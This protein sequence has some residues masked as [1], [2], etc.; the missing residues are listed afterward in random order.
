[1]AFAKAC[2]ILAGQPS[3]RFPRIAP[4]SLSTISSRKKSARELRQRRSDYR[5]CIP[6]LAGFVSPQSIA[7]DGRKT[8]VE[9]DEHPRLN[10]EASKTALL[11]LTGGRGFVCIGAMKSVLG[12]ALLFC[13]TG[14]MTLENRHDLYSPDVELWTH[15][16]RT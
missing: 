3:L 16:Q 6:A 15:P 7:P 10:L 14:C 5:C 12:C 11:T 13:A 2:K 4:F 8:I 1:M 9:K